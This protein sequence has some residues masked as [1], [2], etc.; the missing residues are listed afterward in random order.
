MH[1]GRFTSLMQVLNH[2]QTGVKNNPNVDNLLR[3]PDNSL[4][5]DLTEQEK[6]DIIAFLRTLTDQNFLKDERFSE[7]NNT[8]K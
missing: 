8:I 2:Y 3:K 4:G 7:F 6:Q 1:D 5:I